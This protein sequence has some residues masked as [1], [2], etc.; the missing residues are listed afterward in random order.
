MVTHFTPRLILP[1]AHFQPVTKLLST[2]GMYQRAQR[3]A[4][5]VMKPNTIHLK[6]VVSAWK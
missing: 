5:K 2:G 1:L 6:H 3:D 4:V